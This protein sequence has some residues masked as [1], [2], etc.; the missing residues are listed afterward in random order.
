M[1][2]Y[3]NRSIKILLTEVCP[4]FISII[5]DGRDAEFMQMIMTRLSTADLMQLY[6]CNEGKGF[7]TTDTLWLIFVLVNLQS[8][9]FFKFLLERGHRKLTLR[10]NYDDMRYD[11]ITTSFRPSILSVF[12]E[13]KISALFYESLR[14]HFLLALV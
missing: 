14:W 13:H 1:I 4:E 10:I 2:N 11:A 12:R 8:D 7:Y 9:I 6:M 5:Y 3:Y